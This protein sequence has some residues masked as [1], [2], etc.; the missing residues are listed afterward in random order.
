MTK[1]RLAIFMSSRLL[2]GSAVFASSAVTAG[3][4]GPTSKDD[5]Q[6]ITFL[7]M[8]EVPPNRCYPKIEVCGYCGGAYVSRS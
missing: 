5:K 1:T 4:H 8:S 3:E 7:R 6:V 2:L